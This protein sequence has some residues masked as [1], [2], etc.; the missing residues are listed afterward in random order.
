MKSNEMHHFFDFK[1][2]NEVIF[3]HKI[4]EIT[5]TTSCIRQGKRIHLVNLKS[6]FLGKRKAI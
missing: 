5:N 2:L 6:S 3:V 1:L 4:N